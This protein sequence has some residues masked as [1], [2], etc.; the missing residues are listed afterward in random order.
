M[1]ELEFLTIWAAC[2]LAFFTSCRM[3]EL[4]S[5]LMGDVGPLTWGDIKLKKNKAKLKIKFSK[6][7]NAP[8]YIYIFRSG[9]NKICPISALL[10]LKT[11][12][13][14]NNL[15]DKNESIFKLSKTCNLTKSFLNKWFKKH[16]M[17]ISSHSFRNAIPT[18]ISKHPD[19][20]SD[21][22]V[23]AWG[24]WKSNS[25]LDYQR[26]AKKQ[27]KWMYHKIVNIIF[28]NKLD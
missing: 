5:N 22:H 2:T 18:I 25:F 11:F 6:T 21:N 27:R 12:Q 7:S 9:N 10:D 1:P 23:Q 28:E 4:V 13:I 20:F 14:Q 3:G 15:F 24:R 8:E 16:H 19:I 17:Q 26:A